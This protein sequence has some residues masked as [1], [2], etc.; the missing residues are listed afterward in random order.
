MKNN[1]KAV[2]F[3]YHQKTYYEYNSILL[4]LPKQNFGLKRYEPAFKK[5]IIKLTLV[6]S[7]RTQVIKHKPGHMAKH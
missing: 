2:C 6:W 4:K 3:F 5:D 1:L 7:E